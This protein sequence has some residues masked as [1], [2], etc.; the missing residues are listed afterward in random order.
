MDISQ[1][2]LARLYLYALL[3]GG[4]LGAIYDGLR[5]TRVFLGVHYSRRA[6]KRLQALRL[7]LL[8]ARR[9]RGES[10]ALGTVV[11]FED[12]LFCI[13]AG[14]SLI[15]L[16]YQ[17]NNGKLRFPA[18]L[19]AGAGFLLY[20]WTAGR[21]VMLFSEAIAFFIGTAIRYIIFFIM[22]P[23]RTAAKWSGRRVKRAVVHTVQADRK[24]KR[25]R[26]TENESLRAQK[27][28]CGLVP[29]MPKEKQMP[30]GGRRI[31][32]N[33]KTVQFDASDADPAGHT[34]GSV[35]RRVRQ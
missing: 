16:F 34:R 30:K 33:K 20:R 17:A 27:S 22:L 9:K 29:D 18:L 12:L 2:A 8:P 14:I 31:A 24:N 32:K 7:P 3:L 1:A 26:F 21:C 35:D 19:A 11:F 13:F 28:A 23:F 10:R 5:I 25:R 4:V 6:A 15:L